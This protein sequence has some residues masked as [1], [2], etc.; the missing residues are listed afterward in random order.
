M[1]Y[2]AIQ[3]GLLMSTFE[4]SKNEGWDKFQIKLSMRG[5]WW[6]LELLPLRRLSYRDPRDTTW[7]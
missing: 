3:A 1:S 2:E 5:I 4:G 7:M 6:A